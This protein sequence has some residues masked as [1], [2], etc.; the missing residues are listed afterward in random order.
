MPDEGALPGRPWLAW[1]I[2]A[3]VILLITAALLAIVA[4]G[5]RLLDYDAYHTAAERIGAGLDPYTTPAEVQ[6]TFLIFREFLITRDDTVFDGSER[7]AYIY[8]PSLASWMAGSGL[9]GTG[10]VQSAFILGIAGAITVMTCPMLRGAASAWW[11]LVPALSQDV[12]VQFTNG[13]A[14][15][16]VLALALTGCWLIA[17]AG[18]AMAALA[19]L[20]IA[21]AVLIKPVIGPLI[22]VFALIRLI[23]A[24]DRPAEAARIAIAAALS[25]TL[26][27]LEILRWPGWLRADAW[28]WIA[29]AFD[30][31]FMTLPLAQQEP[32][33]SWNRAPTQILVT[34]GMAAPDAQ[35]AAAV[36][37]AGLLGAALAVMPRRPTGLLPAFALALAISLMLRPTV[38]SVAFLDLAVALT[39]WPVLGVRARRLLLAGLIAL[40]VARW[41][42]FAVAVAGGSTLF[43]GL[44]TTA[45]PWETLVLLPGAAMATLWAMKAR[46]RALDEGRAAP[47]QP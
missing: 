16:H 37:V 3:G 25:L 46:A 1:A 7:P 11:A 14:E 4:S 31:T 35:H 26:V 23:Q 38:W 19:A 9:L 21:A 43:M 15:L 18:S 34:L 10:L 12:F 20:P 42:G 45:L 41:I 32:Y 27:A 30:Y 6:Q 17:R 24:P 44:Q 39:L 13:N 47:Y 5:A 28:Q 33:A 29:N 40:A 8:P 36:V 22:A 2:F